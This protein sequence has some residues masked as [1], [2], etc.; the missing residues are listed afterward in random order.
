MSAAPEPTGVQTLDSLLD[1][2]VGVCFSARDREVI[3]A[4]LVRRED[5]I[6]DLLRMAG[7]QFG[8]FPQIVAEVLAEAGLGTPPTPEVRTMVHQQ[9]HALM[10]AL[11]RAQRGEGP[12][13]QP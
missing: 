9:F 3:Q 2:F 11:A 10:E 4:A 5:Q 8:L 7:Q 13:P 1:D 12:M 6:A